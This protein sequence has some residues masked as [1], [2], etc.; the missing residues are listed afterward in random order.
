MDNKL[1]TREEAEKALDQF[2]KDHPKAEYAVYGEQRKGNERFYYYLPREATKEFVVQK[3]EEF[4]DLAAIPNP[5]PNKGESMKEATNKKYFKYNGPILDKYWEKPMD[6][7]EKDYIRAAANIGQA[8]ILLRK[9]I[10]PDV[11]MRWNDFFLDPAYLVEVDN[12]KEIEEPIEKPICPTCGRRLNDSGTCSVCDD[13][14]EDYGDMKEAFGRTEVEPNFDISLLDKWIDKL[15]EH[16]KSKG[17]VFEE[18]FTY[19]KGSR[20]FKVIKSFNG[21]NRSVFAFVDADGNIYKPAGW[22]APAKGVR[23]RIDNNPP[24]ESI[25][26]YSGRYLKGTYGIDK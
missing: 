19:E 24:L 12:K 3:R 16:E 13:G 22:N 26:L 9:A 17:N 7:T 20:Y 11:Y 8:M 14:E 1:V 25:D 4:H 21:K 23:A 5:N 18:T 10:A 15:N 2:F 6:Y